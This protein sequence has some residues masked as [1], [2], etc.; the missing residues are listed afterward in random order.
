MWRRYFALI[1]SAFSWNNILFNPNFNPFFVFFLKK[2]RDRTTL[3]TVLYR[4]NNYQ[5][6]GRNH[7]R[8]YT[9]VNILISNYVAIKNLNNIKQIINNDI[10]AD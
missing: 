5:A 3:C 6:F 8:F 10:I 1:R 7:L 4:Y 2:K 9:L